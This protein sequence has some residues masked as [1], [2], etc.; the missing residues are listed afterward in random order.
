[1]N[2]IIMLFSERKEVLLGDI[3]EIEKKY[4]HSLGNVALLLLSI[5]ILLHTKKFKN[6]SYPESIPLSR[7]S[8]LVANLNKRCQSVYFLF[9]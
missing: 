4:L 1:M 6:I 3:E 2:E 5:N 9:L 8:G 7:I